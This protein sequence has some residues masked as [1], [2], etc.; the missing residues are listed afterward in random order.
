MSEAPAPVAEGNDAPQPSLV[1]DLRQLAAQGEAY[2]RAEIEYQKS[3]A[4][5][6]GQELRAIAV[7]GTLGLFFVFFALMAL[8]VG[9][10]VALVPHLT[11]WG[12][13]AATTGALIVLAALCAGLARW[14]LGR[15]RKALT[16]DR[17]T[18]GPA[19]ANGEQP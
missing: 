18:A 7:L 15:M 19:P 14:R 11:A 17:T 16:N 1:A 2:A 8:T 5:F 4:A 10:L 3:R 9:V 13:T 12:A 6:A